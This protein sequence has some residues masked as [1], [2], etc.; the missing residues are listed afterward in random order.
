MA[1]RIA[2]IID[3]EDG[4]VNI[5]GLPVEVLMELGAVLHSSYRSCI[6][7]DGSNVDKLRMDI[8]DAINLNFY[9]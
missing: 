6:V 9:K 5:E 3:K 1:T 7:L 4:T 8:K 2:E